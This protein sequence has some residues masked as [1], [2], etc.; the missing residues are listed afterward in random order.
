MVMTHTVCSAYRRVPARATAV[1]LV[2]MAFA[3]PG[4]AQAGDALPQ[5]TLPAS[6]Y[7]HQATDVRIDAEGDVVVVDGRTLT[8][9]AATTI[10][11]EDPE[12]GE[13]QR[14]GGLGALASTRPGRVAYRENADGTLAFLIVL[15]G[16]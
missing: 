13:L 16:R 5:S 3:L 11:V 1:M 15:K 2:C 12:T 10:M 4:T 8:V 6:A 14:A 7:E 9:D